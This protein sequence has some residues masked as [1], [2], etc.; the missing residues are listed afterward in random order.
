MDDA[1]QVNISTGKWE[2]TPWWVN[3][4]ACQEWQH[5]TACRRRVFRPVETRHQNYISV[6][7]HP[8]WEYTTTEAVTLEELMK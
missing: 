5:Q 8:S 2:K 1:W 4:L 7:F 3:F 6:S